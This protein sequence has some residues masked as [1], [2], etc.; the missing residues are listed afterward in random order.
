MKGLPL[1]WC[2]PQARCWLFWQWRTPWQS[3]WQGP[4][5]QGP[6]WHAGAR[7]ARSR[8]ARSGRA[9]PPLRCSSKARA[10]ASACVSRG[11]LAPQGRACTVAR[12]CSGL[13]RRGVPRGWGVGAS[14]RPAWRLRRGKAAHW[15][16]TASRSVGRAK[17]LP[18]SSPRESVPARA[19][20]AHPLAAASR[21]AP[22]RRPPARPRR[23][24][25]PRR[26]HAAVLH[27]INRRKSLQKRV[28][29]PV[30]PR[31]GGPGVTRV[32]R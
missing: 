29:V 26:P 22:A 9:P 8:A 27:G 1:S 12:P 20:M 30:T 4:L 19:G 25:P 3:L 24:R 6:L 2:P 18:T 13:P 11:L 31:F 16:G 15:L 32:T 17:R 5:W 14:R 28:P 21:M 7:W 23:R 10:P